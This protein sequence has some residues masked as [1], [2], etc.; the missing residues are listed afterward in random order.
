MLSHPGARPTGRSPVSAPDSTV[1]YGYCHCG[2][3]SRAPIATRTSQRDGWI[4]GQPKRFI[5]N[6][7][8]RV[9][10]H[11]CNC[12]CGLSRGEHHRQRHAE[13][14]RLWA[15]RHPET[16]YGLCCCGCDRETN[17]AP[18]SNEGR[19]WI[20]DC[21][22]PFL[23]G[24]SAI[25]PPKATHGVNN[26]GG[27]CE[28]GCGEPTSI[29]TSSVT[30]RGYARG[31]P[32]RFLRGHG[33]KYLSKILRA[34]AYV[35]DPRAGCWVWQLSKNPKGYG[36]IWHEGKCWAAHRLSYTLLV[37]PIPE[38]LQLDHL[39]RNTSC[40]NPA[41][42]EPVTNTENQRRGTKCKLTLNDAR[43]I[44]SMHATGTFTYQQ[45]GR[46]FKVSADA[47]GSVIRRESWKE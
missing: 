21:P 32:V 46:L 4:K 10:A 31:E 20:K 47:I 7:H 44:R 34:E 28:C 1:P 23:H 16:P 42:L 12:G 14:R 40:V 37:G 45:L 2:C 33:R 27:L 24:H 30:C 13:H 43:E 5:H 17:I 8:G 38:G 35:V 39:C 6:H 25:L 19:E 15:E 11:P 36:S 41:H 22:E 18:Y 9:A 26:N 29:S 3:G